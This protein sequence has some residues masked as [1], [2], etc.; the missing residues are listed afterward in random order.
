MNTQE[1]T[2]AT[3]VGQQRLVRRYDV[4]DIIRLPHYPT[5]AKGRRRVWQVRGVHLG[6]AGQESIYALKP[7]DV[8]EN[9]PIHV[10]CLMLE[11]HPEVEKLD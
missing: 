4:G 11:T 10:P 6:A 8:S 2:T 5:V 3:T 1:T 7:L 9:E